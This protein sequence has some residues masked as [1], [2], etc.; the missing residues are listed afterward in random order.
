MAYSL[1]LRERVVKAIKAGGKH[2]EVAAY[3]AVGVATLRRYM[4]REKQGKLAADSPP[5]RPADIPSD[6]YSL[7]KKQVR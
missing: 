1:D 6:Q 3:F 4:K 2:E 5:G 7:L